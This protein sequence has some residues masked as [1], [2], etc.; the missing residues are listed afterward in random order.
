MKLLPQTNPSKI[1]MRGAAQGEGIR[2]IESIDMEGEIRICWDCSV[3]EG[4]IFAAC[5]KSTVQWI[6]QSLWDR[7]G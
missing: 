6:L 3:K 5:G 4:A 7:F 2:V 1:R